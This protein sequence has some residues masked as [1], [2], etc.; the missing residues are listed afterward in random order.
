M[1]KRNI[2][3]R[4]IIT[5]MAVA[6]A[7]T[8]WGFAAA[9]DEGTPP[10]LGIGLQAADNGIQVK[11]ITPGSPA[12]EAGLVVGDIITQ[13][14]GKDV[15]ADTVLDI[16]RDYAVGDTVILNVER[17]DET[18]ELNATLATR[19]E[20]P[21]P[22][23]QFMQ[24][25]VLGVR[26]ENTDEGVIIREVRPNSA[27]EKAGLQVGDVL[28][29]IGDTEITEAQQA[30][31][32]VQTLNSGDSVEIQVTR[33]GETV[34]VNATLESTPMELNFEGI[35]FDFSQ[36][37]GQGRL[38]V[39]FVTLN[40][41]V[42]EERN[43]EQTEGALVTSVS[44]DSAA[45]KAG[46]Q[47]DDIIVAVNGE[48]VDE[49]RTLRDR[50]VAYEAGDTITLEIQRGTE[51]LQIEVTLD[52][53][54]IRDMMPMMPFFNGQPGHQFFGPDGFQFPIQPEIQTTQPN[55]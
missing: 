45:E 31:E 33:D 49:E 48:P 34:T 6:V 13:I 39:E 4:S 41:Q 26:L 15:T 9:Q 21:N 51:T 11:E 55:I 23:F 8:A 7:L 42:A 14:D 36:I 54:A 10:F 46:L 53:P 50:L 32:A 29:K 28:I 5:I 35:P 43:L 40:T 30:V 47:A 37:T 52:E 27:A 22:E 18:L 20:Q 1:S 38:G 17:G 19:P 25:P 12:E 2:V 44:A 16:L 24:R 3:F